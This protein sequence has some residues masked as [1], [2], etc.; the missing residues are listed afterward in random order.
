[1][2]EMVYQ[3]S[4]EEIDRQLWEAVLAGLVFRSEDSY[5]FLHDRAQEAAYS[6]EAQ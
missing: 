6:L 2:L 4:L 1:M 5:R 3:E